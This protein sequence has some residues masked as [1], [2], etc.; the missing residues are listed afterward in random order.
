[1]NVRM[2]VHCVGVLLIGAVGALLATNP[3]A[4]VQLNA[5]SVAAY[6]VP[7]GTL[8]NEAIQ[9]L[10]VGNDFRVVSPIAITQLGVFNSGTNG[11]QGS[12]VLT[13]QIY[14]RNGSSGTLLG[15]L[16]FDATNPGQLVGGSLFQPLAVPL[17][18]LP[19]NYSVVAYGFD[20]LNPE[21][22]ACQAP[23]DTQMPPW[24]M[25]DGGGLIQFG[26]SRFG[27]VGVSTFPTNLDIGQTSCYAAGTFLFT[28]TTLP[29]GSLCRGLWRVDDRGAVS[30]P[31]NIGKS[32]AYE[33]SY[34]RNH[35][36]LQCVC[37]DRH[38]KPLWE[39]L[40]SEWHRFS[41]AG[42]TG[43]FPAHRGGSGDL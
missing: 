28:A 17:A 6:N 26:G 12:A 9:G 15:T 23:Y 20:A 29:T 34:P 3:A 18:L 7:F 38:A 31:V 40:S 21:G 43:G 4:A 22:N 33:V 5:T 35:R 27:S 30:F 37:R 13:V 8:G 41:V 32:S 25:N 14:E 16:T 36:Q 10:G 24:T 42:G 19:G 11:I 2:V 39:H 1:M